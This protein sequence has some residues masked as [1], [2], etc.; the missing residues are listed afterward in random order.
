MIMWI[1]QT[2]GTL[3]SVWVCRRWGPSSVLFL[4]F[5]YFSEPR[6]IR[7]RV[8]VRVRVKKKVKAEKK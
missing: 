8:R 6:R 4:S 5:I 1:V 7:R 3:L 2:C